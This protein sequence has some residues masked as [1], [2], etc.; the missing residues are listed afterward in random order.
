MRNLSMKN[1]K[2]YRVYLNIR[3]AMAHLFLFKK[4]ITPVSRNIFIHIEKT[5]KNELNHL[6]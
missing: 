2:V 5:L 6:F 1:N 3:P 4:H